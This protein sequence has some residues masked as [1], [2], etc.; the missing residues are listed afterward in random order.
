MSHI[1]GL[2]KANPFN[3]FRGHCSFPRLQ[4]RMILEDETV[5]TLSFEML[6]NN[7]SGKFGII[8]SGESYASFPKTALNLLEQLN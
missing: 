5:Y 3:T 2:T 7:N 8:G 1:H 6:V 4:A